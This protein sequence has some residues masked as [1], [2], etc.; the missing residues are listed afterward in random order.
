MLMMYRLP[1]AKASPL[2][3]K[4]IELFVMAFVGLLVCYGASAIVMLGIVKLD[5]YH[6]FVG[7][8]IA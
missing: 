4:K 2:A 6:Y 3:R 5:E 8:F 1:G 7:F